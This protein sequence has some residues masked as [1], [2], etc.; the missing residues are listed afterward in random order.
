M[1][2]KILVIL[3]LVLLIPAISATE[4]EYEDDQIVGLDG[5]V[6]LVFYEATA[7]GSSSDLNI[8]KLAYDND[9][10]TTF[11]I[12]ESNNVSEKIVPGL[13]N[14]TIIY[15]Y[16]NENNPT[17]TYTFEVDYSVLDIPIDPLILEY[18]QQIENLTNEYEAEIASLNSTIEN[19]TE[20]INEL[21][22][23]D[24]EGMQNDIAQKN[25]RISELESQIAAFEDKE[26]EIAELEAEIT[27]L[28]VNETSYETTINSYENKYLDLKD[29]VEQ[30]QNPFVFSYEE[31]GK[32]GYKEN[33]LYFNYTSMIIGILACFVFFILFVNK[34]KP[35]RDIFEK[36]AGT[37][38]SKAKQ[39]K[40]TPRGRISN[41][42]Q[43][44]LNKQ[45]EETE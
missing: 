42:E 33:H 11:Y 17:D 10:D 44:Y 26:D 23:Y 24:I 21:E 5:D 27:A 3:T 18:Q 6:D 39:V 41:M 13:F 19:L 1:N 31:P 9:S 7:W 29:T 12:I 32:Y 25:N 28:K 34:F 14:G 43:E 40:N 30:L 35:I 37:A 38:M 15:T 2:K 20:E 16:R 8:A 36:I 45:K 4:I 22:S